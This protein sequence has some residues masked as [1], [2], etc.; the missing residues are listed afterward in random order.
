MDRLKAIETFKIVGKAKSFAEAASQLNVTR[1]IVG[2]RIAQL[3]SHLKVR[4]FDRTTRELKLT[5]EGRQYLEACGRILRLLLEEEEALRISKSAPI[6]EFKILSAGSFGRAQLMK[7]VTE[8]MKMYPAVRIEVELTQTPPTP[9]QLV[10]RGFD[11]GIRIYAPPPNSRIVMRKVC[12][13][14]WIACATPEYLTTKTAPLVPRDLDEH[15]VIVAR[16]HEQ[17]NLNRRGKIHSFAPNPA[18]MVSSE[19]VRPTILAHAGI[20]LQPLYAV[21]EDIRMGRIVPLIPGYSDPSGQIFAVYPHARVRSAKVRLFTN[22]L[23]KTSGKRFESAALTSL[24]PD[25]VKK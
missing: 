14:D 4:L 25:Q 3:E 11:I 15:T 13:Y 24:K 18:I 12:N 2:R 8:F 19:A 1:A 20:G 5:S 6:G 17:W 10:E 22:F 7:V 23:V 9:L 16:G 21:E